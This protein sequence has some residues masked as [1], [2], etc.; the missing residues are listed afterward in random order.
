MRQE[1]QVRSAEGYLHVVVAGAFEL[2]E[3]RTCI[4]RLLDACLESR[5]WNVLVDIRDV[6]R[7]IPAMARYGLAEFMAAGQEEPLRMAILTSDRHLPE[8]RFFEDVAVNRGLDMKAFVDRGESVAWLGG[9]PA[10]RTDAADDRRVR[11]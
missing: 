9:A 8:D 1:I 4:Q 3:A 10:G 7:P 5:I 6:A 2:E 11:A